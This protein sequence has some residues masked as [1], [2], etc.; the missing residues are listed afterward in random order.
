MSLLLNGSAGPATV[1]IDFNTILG[2]HVTEAWFANLLFENCL[3]DHQMTQALF[4]IMLFE[5]IAHHEGHM[6][7]RTYDMLLL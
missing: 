2:Q 3:Q 7:C 6:N 4:G 1:H 5:R